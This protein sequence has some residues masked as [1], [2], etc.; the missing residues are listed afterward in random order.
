MKILIAGASGLIGSALTEMFESSGATV[1]K[2]VR[3]RERLTDENVLWEPD[4]EAIDIPKL[5]WI[6]GTDGFRAVINLAGENIGK[7]RWSDEYKIRMR[8]S[9]VKSTALLSRALTELEVK[10]GVLVNASAI[11]IYGDRGETHIDEDTPVGTSGFLV[12]LSK[13]WEDATKPASEAGIRVV[14]TRFGLVLSTKGGALKKM[15]AFAKVG[16]AAPIGEGN[17][18]WSWITI[19]DAVRAIEHVIKTESIS[20]PVNV[21]NTNPLR[22][23]D[24]SRSMMFYFKAPVHMHVP[25]F[26][27]K[28]LLG[29]MA[30]ETLLASQ[31]VLPIKLRQTGFKFQ[32]T[33]LEAALR[34]LTSTR[35][36]GDD[37]K[38]GM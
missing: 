19:D 10:P 9:R 16:G 17:Q 18:W 7:G 22:N 13:K 28:G 31:K 21:V 2:M 32:H 25:A 4:R 12:E 36:E 33:K 20:G 23:I 26:L 3:D 29:E 34:H 35:I 37:W 1:V 5:D 30:S 24:F 6:G 11:G 27:L 14:L 38:P 15:I 8:D